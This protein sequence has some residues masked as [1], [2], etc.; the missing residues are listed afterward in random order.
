[1][2]E[3]S[4]YAER[5][6]CNERMIGIIEGIADEL[7]TNAIYN[8]PRDAAGKPKYAALSRRETVVLEP[9]ETAVLE[10]ACD[11]NFIALSQVDPFGSLTQETIVNYLNRCLVQG[12]AAISDGSPAFGG[13]GGAGIGLYRMFQSLSKFIVNIEPGKRT[14][15]I[16][17]IDLRVSMK[18][19]RQQAKSFHIFIA[20]GDAGAEV[21]R[22]S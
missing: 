6:G 14:E 1:M 22:G 16:A 15:V 12:A 3:V 20:D 4:R 5:L 18:K 9:H 21:G 7:I 10:F 13:S 8:A 11:G 2:R 17:L 19:F